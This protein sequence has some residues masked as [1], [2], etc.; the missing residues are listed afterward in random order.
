LVFFIA[1]TSPS[2]SLSR[3]SHDVEVNPIDES[4]L[5]DRPGVSGAPAQ[6]VAVGLAGSS[7]VLPDDRRERDELDGVDLNLTRAD[8]VAAAL[9]D[10][11]PLPQSD[12]ER[13]V[14]ARTSLRRTRLNST[15]RDASW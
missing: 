14:L 10:L 2:G 12:R 9:P 6:R 1:E 5:V 13:D 3:S 8:P 7:D 11:R 15:L 4:V